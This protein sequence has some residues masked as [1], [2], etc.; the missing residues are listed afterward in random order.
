VKSHD[1]VVVGAGMAGSAAAL[2]LAQL[3]QDAA[4]LDA[5]ADPSAGG[6]TALSGGGLH[7]ARLSL[8][9]KPARLL[10]RISLAVAPTNDIPDIDGCP[11]AVKVHLVRAIN[12]VT[13]GPSS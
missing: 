11:A 5:A 2:R 10:R 8:D 12:I 6:N 1:A 13:S 9:S 4:L 3:G 7:I